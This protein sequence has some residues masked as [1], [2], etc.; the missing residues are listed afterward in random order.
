MTGSISQLERLVSE[1]KSG[2]RRRVRWGAGQGELDVYNRLWCA[3]LLTTDLVETRDPIFLNALSQL[4]RD[5]KRRWDSLHN[6]FHI[7]YICVL[8]YYYKQLLLTGT[9]TDPLPVFTA[10][11][12]LRYSINSHKIQ[13]SYV[14]H[15]TLYINKQQGGCRK[16]CLSSQMIQ[17][18]KM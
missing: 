7:Q 14:W 5:G 9:A 12:H 10:F 1:Q 11:L 16:C 4:E 3:A 18:Q 6:Y 17:Y 13:N 15:W 2:W 8:P